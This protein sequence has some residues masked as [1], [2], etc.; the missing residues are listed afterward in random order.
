VC[1]F[2]WHILVNVSVDEYAV[3][4]NVWMIVSLFSIN[5][6]V[7]YGIIAQQGFFIGF[8]ISLPLVSGWIEKQCCSF[9]IFTHFI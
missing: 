5:Y 9:G 3:V 6:V 7:H 8:T 4:S 1:S 2:K